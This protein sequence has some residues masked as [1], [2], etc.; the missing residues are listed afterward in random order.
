VRLL[1]GQYRRLADR[2]DLMH[3]PEIESR[4]SLSVLRQAELGCLGRWQKDADVGKG[5]IAVVMAGEW[6]Q[7]LTRLEGDLEEPVSAAVEAAQKP[8][9]R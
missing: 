8:W 3:A 6:V 1:L 9:W 7:N 2:L 5:A 4:V